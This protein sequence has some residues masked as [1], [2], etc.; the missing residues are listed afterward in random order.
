[1]TMDFGNY[2]A[3][4]GKTDMAKYCIQCIQSV[5]DQLTNLNISSKIGVTPMIGVNDIQDE[6][7]TLDNATELINYCYKNDNIKLLSFW[8]INRD[9]GNK[10]NYNYADCN[11]S[12]IEQSLYQFS[13]IF[14]KINK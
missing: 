6:I 12:G 5:K 9:N 4:N 14:N 2:Y 13:C 3:P 10:V 11:Y 7:F 1:M 8:C